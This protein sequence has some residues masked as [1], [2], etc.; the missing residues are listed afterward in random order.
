MS[1]ITIS[2]FEERTGYA[3]VYFSQNNKFIQFLKMCIKPIAL[4]Y[5]N[6]DKECWMVHKDMLPATI[7]YARTQFSQ[8]KVD[9]PPTIIIDPPGTPYTIGDSPDYSGHSSPFKTMFLQEDAPKELIQVA[10]K[11]LALLFHPDRG[12]NSEDMVKLNQAYAELAKRYN[13][14]R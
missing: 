2:E 7:K 4:R 3:S 14:A 11:T 1:S 5:Y 12:G 6:P 8:I 10:Y 9:L 13:L